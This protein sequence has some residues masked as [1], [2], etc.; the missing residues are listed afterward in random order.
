MLIHKNMYNFLSVCLSPSLSVSLSH[1]IHTHFT[2]ITVITGLNHTYTQ[3]LIHL[4]VCLSV[5]LSVSLHLCLSHAIAIETPSSHTHRRGS[6]QFTFRRHHYEPSRVLYV[7]I[8]VRLYLEL[9][10]TSHF[11]PIRHNNNVYMIRRERAKVKLLV[12]DAAVT[13]STFL[14]LHMKQS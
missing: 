14:V 8:M 9:P 10:I 3:K 4:S 11:R 5:C 7:T 1:I 2:T 12:G 13:K 6:T